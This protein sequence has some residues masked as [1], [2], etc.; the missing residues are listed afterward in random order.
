MDGYIAKPIHAADLFQAVEGSALYA[1]SQVVAEATETVP[2]LDTLEEAGSPLDWEE[3]LAR[4]DGNE[5]LLQELAVLFCEEGTRLMT[6]IREAIAQG[7]T[8]ELRR[9]AHT[10]K[11]SAGMFVAKPAVEA[12]L[13]LEAMAR[14]GDLSRIENACSSLDEAMSRLLPALRDVAKIDGR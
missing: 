13:R 1:K 12:A 4:L 14:D 6:G 10:L 5:A 8:D 7:E 3:A 11:G 2:L 9:A